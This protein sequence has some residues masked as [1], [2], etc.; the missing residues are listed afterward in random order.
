MTEPA[1]PTWQLQFLQKYPSQTGTSVWRAEAQARRG[2]HPD[3]TTAPALTTR[4]VVVKEEHPTGQNDRHNVAREAQLL[5]KLQHPHIISVLETYPV[6]FHDGQQGVRLVLPAGQC[7]LFDLV[8]RGHTR[9]DPAG[10]CPAPQYWRHLE[11]VGRQILSALLYLHS[12]QVAHLDLSLENVVL[13][14]TEQKQPPDVSVCAKL[15]DFGG[16]VHL[17]ASVTRSV[18]KMGYMAPEFYVVEHKNNTFEAS[19]SPHRLRLD[20]CDV[21]SLGAL[22]FAAVTA[23]PPYQELVKKD[24]DGYPLLDLRAEPEYPYQLTEEARRTLTQPWSQW[25]PDLKPMRDY[26]KESFRQY[27]RHLEL[28]QVL[29]AC[30][31][32]QPGK[33]KS[34]PEVAQL[35]WFQPRGAK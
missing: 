13:F 27:E 14:P 26:Q 21:F 34:L 35:P 1:T 22:L 30:L 28:A 11:D 25:W 7:D 23:Q 31:C 33:R 32:L 8:Y 15:I 4:T 19:G 5:Q 17:Q 16:A 29:D 3:K 20:L 10:R 2:T 18:G 9:A 6:R 12:E 24:G